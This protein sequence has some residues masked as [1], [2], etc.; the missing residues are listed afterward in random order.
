MSQKANYETLSVTTPKEFVYHVELN[1]PNQLNAM[2]NT[3]WL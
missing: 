1:R 3:L 2:N